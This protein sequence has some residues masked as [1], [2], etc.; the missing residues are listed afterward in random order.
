MKIL[1]IGDIFA[2][3]GRKTIQKLLPEIIQE[4]TPDL[5]IAN[6]ENL[7]HGNGFSPE[8]ITA[9]QEAGI[10]FFTSGDH[11]WGN[12]SGIMKLNDPNFPVIRPA[13]YPSP[14]T[15][16]KGYKIIEDGNLN[17]ILIISLL[18]RVFMKKDY[19][20]PFKKFDQILQETAHENPNAIFIDFHTEATSEIAAFGFYADGKASIVVGTHTHV[21]TADTRILEHNTAFMTDIG[22]TGPLDSVI[23]VK[24]D[25]IINSFL[26]QMPVK[27][28]PELQGKMVLNAVLVGIDEKTK[29][30]QNIQHIQKFTD[31]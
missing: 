6:A 31:L 16:G 15:P 17:K 18:G 14:N 23:G 30:A 1:A 29:K 20:C 26:T 12:K 28:E 8:H 10:N 2:K 5:V 27:H 24:K 3:S 22:M 21:P 4:H 11:T 9:M 7:S 13:N 19:D 25:I